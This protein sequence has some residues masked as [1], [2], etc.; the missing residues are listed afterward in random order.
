VKGVLPVLVLSACSFAQNNPHGTGQTSPAAPKSLAAQCGPGLDQ[1]P[2]RVFANTGK[3][4]WEEQTGAKPAHHDAVS[5]S[6]PTFEVFT[7]S[8]GRHFVRALNYGTGSATFQT[9]CYNEAGKLQS[10]H[11]EMRTGQGWGYQDI[12]QFGAQG[13]LLSHKTGFFDT[14]DHKQVER[15]PEADSFPDFTKPA[16]YPSFDA[17]PFIAAFKKRA[18]ATQK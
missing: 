2:K 6:G 16:I 8:A 17:L 15:P 10:M 1:A 9:S 18:N 12:R 4:G 13:K 7:S 3:Q 14:A 11:Y 5:M